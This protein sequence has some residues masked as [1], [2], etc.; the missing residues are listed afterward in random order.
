MQRASNFDYMQT[1]AAPLAELRDGW[2]NDSAMKCNTK[3]KSD[4]C[5]RG[6]A[7]ESHPPSAYLERPPKVN[8]LHH[9]PLNTGQIG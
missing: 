9:S 5:P 2:R 6:G 1:P 7:H 3:A 4:Q 8:H